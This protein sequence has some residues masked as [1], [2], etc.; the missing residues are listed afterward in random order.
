M[1]VV[2]DALGPGRLALVAVEEREVDVRGNVELFAAQLAECDHR[3][4]RSACRLAMR[5]GDLALGLGHGRGDALLRDRGQ[6][7]MGEGDHDALAQAPQACGD[8]LAF[9]GEGGT[10]LRALKG[11]GLAP[12]QVLQ[13]IRS[14][15]NH[16]C[17][18]PGEA[19]GAFEVRI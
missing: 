10:H 17:H 2:R 8:G 6:V 3:E 13:H 19:K 12:P 18:V 14:R 5:R 11:P 4:A 1:L 16:T 7:A 15:V 9:P